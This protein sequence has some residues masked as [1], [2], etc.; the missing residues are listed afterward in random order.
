MKRRDLISH[1]ESHGCRWFRE[2]K[3]HSL[4]WNP[5]SNKTSTV[6]RHSEVNHFLA[7]KICSDLGIEVYHGSK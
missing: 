5:V 4:Y 2:G 7:K 3:R 6:P 1:L